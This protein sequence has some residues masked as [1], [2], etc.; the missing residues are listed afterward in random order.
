[1]NELIKCESNEFVLHVSVRTEVLF[2][3]MNALGGV[4]VQLHS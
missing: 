2:R 3:L 4:D 1:M